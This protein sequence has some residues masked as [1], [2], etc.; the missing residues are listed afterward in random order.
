[1]A[2]R[3]LNAIL[4]AN[5]EIDKATALHAGAIV[6][7]DPSS[8]LI[9]AADRATHGQGAYI[10]VLADDTARTGNTMIL[11]DPVGSTYVDTNGVLQSNANGYYR[12]AKRAIGDYQSEIV[13][14]VTNPTAGTSGYEGPRRGVG[15]Y[16]TPSNNLV[17]DQFATYKTTDPNGTTWTET[18]FTGGDTFNPNDLLTFGTGANAGLLVKVQ[19]ATN[20]GRIVAR[21]DKYDAAGGMLWITML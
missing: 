11:V 18:A 17:T 6:A 2:V 8:S 15:V 4:N 13:N 12:V 3:E 20:N 10:G 19:A 1:M 7:R 5:F 9:V 14:G 16:T 21:V